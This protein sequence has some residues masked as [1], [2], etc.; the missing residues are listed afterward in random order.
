LCGASVV[1]FSA[2]NPISRPLQ[3]QQQHNSQKG[4][5]VVVSFDFGLE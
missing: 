3:Q 5:G 2:K 1:S 4:A